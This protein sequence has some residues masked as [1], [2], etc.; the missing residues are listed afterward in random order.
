MDNLH[1]G[2]IAIG[3]ILLAFQF[4]NLPLAITWVCLSG[5]LYVYRYTEEH[6][7]T[8][9]GTHQSENRAGDGYSFSDAWRVIFTG[10]KLGFEGLFVFVSLA[11]MGALKAHPILVTVGLGWGVINAAILVVGV[12]FLA[13]LKYTQPKVVPG[14]NKVELEGGSNTAKEIGQSL[15]CAA[16]MVLF[17]LAPGLGSASGLFYGLAGLMV[18]NS[19]YK[20]ASKI[21][22]YFCDY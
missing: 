19:L 4:P 12:L 15:V 1:W 11:A 10:G 21:E 7:G 22:S 9:D 6:K 18:F 13:V 5:A 20:G 3:I 14:E 16:I 17:A 2:G 8:P